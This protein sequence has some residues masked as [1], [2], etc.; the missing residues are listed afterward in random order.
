MKPELLVH[1]I[2]KVGERMK[3][4]GHSLIEVLMVVLLIGLIGGTINIG[5][6]LVQRASFEKKVVEVE[7]GIMWARDAATMT[8]RRYNIYCLRNRVLVRQGTEKPKHTIRLSEGLYI[9]RDIT[10]KFIRFNG[11]MASPRTGTITIVCE[12]LGLQADITV[13]VATGKTTVTYRA[14]S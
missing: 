1:P 8:G 7:Q 12:A 13:R 11:T 9:P 5:T 2:A 6:Y 14:L 10:G 3:E 4:S